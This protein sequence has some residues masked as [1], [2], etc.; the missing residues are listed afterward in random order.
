M[1][2]QKIGGVQGVGGSGLQNGTFD[3]LGALGDTTAD[4]LILG[5]TNGASN[6]SG[7]TGYKVVLAGDAATGLSGEVEYRDVV[8][9]PLVT[10]NGF[11]QF[12]F[13]DF[14]NIGANEN[15]IVDATAVTS[16]LTLNTGVGNDTV[17][18]GG[19][20]DRFFVSNGAFGADT[21]NGGAGHDTLDLSALTGAARTPFTFKGTNLFQ[22][23]ALF[24]ERNS[25]PANTITFTNFEAIKSGG[26]ND[27]FT[28]GYA[29]ETLKSVEMGAG[30]DKF[31]WLI[32]NDVDLDIDAGR[33]N[34]IV[35][36]GGNSG[37]G[38][39]GL[40][41]GAIAGGIG[42][43]TLALGETNGHSGATGFKVVIEND[44]ESGKSF[45]GA[46]QYTDGATD[47]LGGTTATFTGFEAFA[48]N[49]RIAATSNDHVDATA[50]THDLSLDTGAGNDTV[51]FGGGDDTFVIGSRTFGADTVDGGAGH[52]T[53]DLSAVTGAGRS[54]FTFKGTNLFQSVDLVVERT[55]ATANKVTFTDFE[56]IK[57]G[58]G[59]DV[60]TAGYALK[61]LKRIEM[62]DGA[63]R[64][65]W[66]TFNG[67]ALDIDA[68]RGSDT[69]MIGGTQGSGHTGLIDGAVNGG[70]GKDTLF[71]RFNNTDGD[72]G[73]GF[74]VT[75]TGDNAGAVTYRGA[76]NGPTTA[77]ES[78][79][80]VTFD[81]FNRRSDLDDVVDA[82]ASKASLTINTAAGDD[83]IIVAGGNDLLTGGRGGD[84]FAFMGKF[85]KDTI[86]DF[87]VDE[88]M[89][90]LQSTVT[91]VSASGANTVVTTT[92]GWIT[93]K[94]VTGLDIDTIGSIID[95]TFDFA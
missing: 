2:E 85:G 52:D 66:S 71:V 42:A 27:V 35:N 70:D 53:L 32:F 60:F 4:R 24:V 5:P 69:V 94:G 37:S 56:A 9:G 57:S 7:A 38:R 25:A 23:T 82:R 8:N 11:E 3:I 6:G 12:A 65:E 64:F 81:G 22:T 34:D 95:T 14:K 19:G 63:D 72:T 78:F 79:E 36:I 48:F 58:G 73:N 62:G 89:I 87:N 84:T 46:V 75:F 76:T 1:I 61:A 55:D 33:G 92:D 20:N 83:T 86:T 54:P 88:D 30:D 59:D 26:D 91:A 44:A 39:T 90:A 29:P 10:F 31:G 13:T 18:F 51:M 43:D 50:A 45:M 17:M 21:V 68:G 41:N 47:G 80:V 16:G 15:D 28:V 67:D 77:F 74:E 40:H 93:L 49:G